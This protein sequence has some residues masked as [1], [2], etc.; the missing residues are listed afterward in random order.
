MAARDL[1]DAF[2]VV[3]ERWDSL[4]LRQFAMACCRRVWHLIPDEPVREL[5]LEMFGENEPTDDWQSL[6]IRAREVVSVSW[7]LAASVILGSLR[8]TSPKSAYF[9]ADGL[10]KALAS[11]KVPLP[12]RAPGPID[13]DAFEW[14]PIPS[15]PDWQAVWA[16]E[17]AAQALLVLELFPEVRSTRF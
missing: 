15:D 4:R 7:G 1:N 11:S 8:F 2:D 6:W 10:A 9:F 5:V 12:K 3:G 13:W 17:R 14:D 16:A